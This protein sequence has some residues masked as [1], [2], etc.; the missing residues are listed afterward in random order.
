MP[1]A[2]QTAAMAPTLQWVTRPY[3]QAPQPVNPATPHSWCRAAV[4]AYCTPQP[5]PAGAAFTAVQLSS[6]A[7]DGLV[8][9]SHR[10]HS[11]SGTGSTPG[12][13]G[14]HAQP[15]AR[16]AA[17][18]AAQAP[19][20]ATAS[21]GAGIVVPAFDATYVDPP[22]Q[23]RILPDTMPPLQDD[24]LAQVVTSH[25]CW[26]SHDITA[27]REMSP[28]P[29]VASEGLQLIWMPLPA[30]RWRLRRCGMTCRPILMQ[31]W[32]NLRGGAGICCWPP[33]NIWDSLQQPA[34]Q[35][36]RPASC[37][38]SVSA[39]ASPNLQCYR[40]RSTVDCRPAPQSI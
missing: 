12:I 28:I 36:R 13:A 29:F 7:A 26:P 8:L 4:G 32:T 34:L 23:P 16:A 24:F 31:Q 33:S 27:I 40:P 35:R 14:V 30:C 21:A 5:L 6:A 10:L 3:T 2:T 39:A 17:A 38:R 15:M 1:A 20:Q 9:S 11:G 37:R 19:A 25:Q 18:G 22:P